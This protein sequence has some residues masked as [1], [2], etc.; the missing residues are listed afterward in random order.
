MIKFCLCFA[1]VCI[2]LIA[3]SKENLP[4][5]KR[6]LILCEA[7]ENVKRKTSPKEEQEIDLTWSN[8]KYLFA[9]SFVVLAPVCKK[10]W[11]LPSDYTI[12]DLEQALLDALRIYQNDQ[13]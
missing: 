13:P 11:E 5:D 7:W 6:M 4:D 9:K 1:L 2:L 8:D 10:P 12:L 3:T